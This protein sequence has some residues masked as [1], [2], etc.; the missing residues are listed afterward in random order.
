MVLDGRARLALGFQK[1]VATGLPSPSSFFY[2]NKGTGQI[3][4]DL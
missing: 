4:E 2:N 1:E 3:F